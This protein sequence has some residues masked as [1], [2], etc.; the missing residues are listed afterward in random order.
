MP[1]PVYGISPGLSVL[2]PVKIKKKRTKKRQMI[3]FRKGTSAVSAGKNRRRGFISKTGTG[4]RR[5]RRRTRKRRGG[6]RRRKQ[7]QQLAA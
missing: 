3:R 4:R 2:Q 7:Q 5:R 6:R 1:P